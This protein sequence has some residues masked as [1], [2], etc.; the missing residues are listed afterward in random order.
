MSTGWNL[1]LEAG[2][3]V[4]IDGV[5]YL[6]ERVDPDG[7]VTLRPPT[8]FS[9][10]DFMVVDDDGFPRKPTC[11]EIGAL[12]RE[13]RLI[14]R[15][16]PL[17]KE[18]R[19]FAR[20]Q[21]WDAEQA[22]KLDPTCQFRTAILR[23]Y[24][25]CPCSKSDKALL[26]FMKGALADP[27]IA[28]LPDAWLASPP[29][30]RDWLRERGTVHQRKERD[31][32][33][34]TGR[35]RKKR[36]L[37]H[38]L[39]ILKYWSVRAISVRG[40]IQKNYDRYQAEITR[41]NAGQPP[42]RYLL[43]D[44]EGDS[45]Q[46]GLV[47]ADYGRPE[48]PYVPI[49]YSSFWR[50]CQELKNKK[51]Y[52]LKTTKRAGYARYGGGGVSDLPTHVGA[53]C[54]IDDTPVPKTFFVDGETGIPIGDAVMTLMLEDKSRVIPGWDL[55]PGAGSTATLLR[56]VL[57]AN[58]PK[59]VP[60]D[61]LEIDDNLPWLRLRP[62]RIGFDNS[63]AQHG[64][65]AED[66][67]GDA[68]IG[69]RFVGSD[70]PRDK[71]H[72]EAVIGTFLDLIFNHQED[73]NYDI[74]RMRRYG[75]DP[76]NH[77]ICSIETGR[78]LLARAV[79]T[80]NVTRNR[81]L[82]KRQPALMWKKELGHRKLPVLEDVD[83]FAREIGR[84]YDKDITLT[85]A[86]IEKFN[87]RYTAGAQKMK[88]VIQDFESARH[89]PVG[90]IT[91]KQKRRSRDDRKTL[92]FS[93]KIRVNDDDIGSMQVWNPHAKTGAEWVTFYCTDPATE[94][95]P[96][97][98]HKRCRELAEREAMEYCTPQQQAVVRARLF[99]EIANV[100]AA[101]AERERATLGKA[102]D[103]QRVRQTFGQYVEVIDE[104]R[105][106]FSP[107]PPERYSSALNQSAAPI[108]KDAA[109]RTPRSRRNLPPDP[110][111]MKRRITPAASTARRAR[112][113]RYVDPRN[114]GSQR[115]LAP[116]ADQ[117]PHGSGRSRSTRVKW[118]DV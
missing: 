50:L 79:M 107:R 59:D 13:N 64:R 83:R 8:G 76:A 42:D 108:R 22:R 88:E 25:E 95:M 115:K 43:I 49:S 66:N 70:M 58:A 7:A 84:V 1:S 101:A 92:S 98:L 18:A 75:F 60:D 53:L 15:G 104:P 44:P 114:A 61:I 12:V 69:T 31:G 10:P 77:V 113:S 9:Q 68:Y 71:S 86:G 32:I 45:S 80:Y 5:E 78:R 51:N 24:D 62:D 118:G 21:E 91:P 63:T 54:W 112:N 96:L 73:A 100:D 116:S 26:E 14:V 30:V 40:D 90:D 87:R 65:S 55:S 56:T 6:F 81:S 99:E 36:K 82:D 39:E 72:M 27:E 74:A 109:V 37:G 103:N 34:M 48:K 47:P 93:V 57:C 23:R 17:S 111:R 20:Q 33:S 41:I 38:P 29:T 16:R 11:D 102:I 94:G 85:P 106:Q 3:P 89:I 97:W 52:E 105:E 2:D 19:R 35:M 46:V 4:E 67:L 117:R 110:E 28:G